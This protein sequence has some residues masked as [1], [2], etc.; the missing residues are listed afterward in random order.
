MARL[1]NPKIKYSDPLASLKLWMPNMLRAQN[2][3]EALRE[4]ED[5]KTAAINAKKIDQQSR[6]VR[7]TIIYR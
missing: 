1:Y 2:Y 3:L 5:K 6:S 4:T 7:Y